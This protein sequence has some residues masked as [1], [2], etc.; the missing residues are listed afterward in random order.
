MLTFHIFDEAGII[1]VSNTCEPSSKHLKRLVRACGGK[2]TGI[3]AKANIVVGKTPQM[4]NNI[5]EKWILDCIT[6][7]ILLNK[8]QYLYTS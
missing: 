1:Y 7:G 8:D 2:C 4:N 3:E 5:N 6:H